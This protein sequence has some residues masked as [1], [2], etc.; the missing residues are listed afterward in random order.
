MLCERLTARWPHGLLPSPCLVT[1]LPPSFLSLSHF[2]SSP[3]SYF[4]FHCLWPRAFLSPACGLVPPLSPWYTLTPLG[5]SGFSPP[6][7]PDLADPLTNVFPLHYAA[8][9][10]GHTGWL[11]KPFPFEEGGPIPQPLP[12]HIP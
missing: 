4:T 12:S 3:F 7:G 10:A 9:R 1:S 11:E 2:P 6:H 5:V 8:D